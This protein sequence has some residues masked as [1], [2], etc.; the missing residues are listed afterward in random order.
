MN[1]TTLDLSNQGLKSIEDIQDMLVQCAGQMQTLNLAGNYLKYVY[2]II[3][4][5]KY[6]NFLY[7]EILMHKYLFRNC[8]ILF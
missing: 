4:L 6:F 5:K 2:I 1:D 3:N 8:N 7:I